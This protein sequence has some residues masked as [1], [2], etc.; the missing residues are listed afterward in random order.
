MDAPAGMTQALALQLSQVY[1]N[2]ALP[3]CQRV[4]ISSAYQSIQGLDM[5]K[6][7]VPK[8]GARPGNVIE[9]YIPVTRL[10]RLRGRCFSAGAKSNTASASD[11]PRTGVLSSDHDMHDSSTT[12]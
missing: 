12:M 9:Y 10:Y 2:T 7:T 11:R 3:L 1:L 5:R 4:G 8:R 6:L